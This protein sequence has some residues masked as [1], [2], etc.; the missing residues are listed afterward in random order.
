M[1]V[2]ADAW[3]R[4]IDPEVAAVL[5]LVPRLDLTDLPV[6]RRERAALAARAA[7]GHVPPPSVRTEDRRIPGWPDGSPDVTVR[8]HEPAQAPP[9]SPP[10]LLWVHGGGHVL[11]S[12]A[13]D[14]PLLQDL[15]ARTGCVAVAV[16]WRRAPEDP[17]PAAVHDAYAALRWLAAR[18]HPNLVVGGASSGGGVAAGVAL[19]ARDQGEVSLAGQLLVYPMLDDRE[20]TPS[21]RE[22]RDPRLWNHESNRLGWA[23]YL[24][25]LDG[26]P[27]PAYAAPA[28]AADV[29]G[30]P[31]TWLA[32]G[33]LDLFRDED[34]EYAS[35]LFAAGVPTELHVYPGAVHGFDLF[36]PDAAVSRRYRRDRDEALDRFVGIAPNAG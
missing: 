5:D 21:S 33:E 27:V 2:A 26:R 36:A 31:P 20:V 12:A 17:Y 22:V 28:R 15:V 19:L 11:G 16:E 3:E 30:L 25:G 13:Q 29:S 4:R 24:S 9:S 14:D 32:T 18:D 1:T 23:A 6:A 35:R 34:V 8:V 10:A 7:A